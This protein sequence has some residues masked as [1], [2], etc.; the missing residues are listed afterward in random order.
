M[1]ACERIRAQIRSEFL[2]RAAAERSWSNDHTRSYETRAKRL[3]A[4]QRFDAE[5]RTRGAGSGD[6]PF[7]SRARD[8]EG[9]KNWFRDCGHGARGIRLGL[10]LRL[11]LLHQR[12]PLLML[13][14]LL[15]K[16]EAEL[17]NRTRLL[18][19]K[20]YEFGALAAL[21]R[22]AGDKKPLLLSEEGIKNRSGALMTLEFSISKCARNA[23]TPR[24]E[25]TTS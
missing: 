19:L 10:L 6:P 7:S 21:S 1:H 8:E 23:K 3:E 5:I 11:L 15:C 12:R 18:L 14:L 9:R 17:I 2:R 22:K 25:P 24:W 4:R 20:V 13:L 16:Y